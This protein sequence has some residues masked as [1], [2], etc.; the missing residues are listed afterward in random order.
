MKKRISVIVAFVVIFTMVVSLPMTSFATG[1]ESDLQTQDVVQETVTAEAEEPV[2]SEEEPVQELQ[3]EYNMTSRQ[4]GTDV[5]YDY[6]TSQNAE[7]LQNDEVSVK[8]SN[9][10]KLDF[11]IDG[12]KIVV[13]ASALTVD[14]L[15]YLTVDGKTFEADF[16][17][18]EEPAAEDSAKEEATE[19]DSDVSETDSDVAVEEEPAAE[20]EADQTQQPEEG[21]A[22]LET[23]ETVIQLEDMTLWT[24]IQLFSNEA[25][26]Y[27]YDRSLEEYSD[28]DVSGSEW[29]VPYTK[30]G[31]IAWTPAKLRYVVDQYGDAQQYGGYCMDF[32][33][34]VVDKSS[35]SR[36]TLGEADY[37]DKAV[38]GNLRSI[39]KNS[40]PVISLD[41]LISNMKA[42]GYSVS[43]LTMGQAVAGTQWA[44]WA[45]SNTASS[46]VDIP[47]KA[48][49]KTNKEKV[50]R[51]LYDLNPVTEGYQTEPIVFDITSYQKDDTVIF[52]YSNTSNAAA[53]AGLKDLDITVTDGNGKVLDYTT[54]GY[55]IIV[56]ISGME[57]DTKIHLTISGMQ[58]LAGD[59]YF[60]WPEQTGDSQRGS[61]QSLVSYFD[62]YTAVK[63]TANFS[64]DA[65][66]KG[67][68][69]LKG[70]KVLAG[71]ELTSNDSFDFV[72]KDENGKTVS[73]GT[74]NG[75]EITFEPITY[76]N[77]QVGK[78]FTYYA[79]EVNGGETVN[80]VTYDNSNLKFTVSVGF[81]N[82]SLA[83]DVVYE[84]GDGIEFTNTYGAKETSLALKVK[85]ELTGNKKM[86]AGMFDFTKVACDKDGN[87]LENADAVTA[88]NNENGEVLFGEDS[89]DKAGTYYYL[90]TENNG[91]QKID[92]ITY[93]NMK[94]VVKV[95]VEDNLEGDL[96][97]TAAYPEDVTFD[98]CYEA[99]AAK[100]AFGGKKVLEGRDLKA[101]EYEFTLSTGGTAIETVTNDAEG[102]ISFS[103]ITYTEAGEYTYT[104]SEVKGDA[105]GVT[106]DENVYTVT[107]KV[108]DDGLGQL[109]A[110]IADQKQDIVFSNTYKGVGQ[111]SVTKVFLMND[112]EA[113]ITTSFEVGLFTDADCTQKAL[114][115]D[116]SEVPNQMIEM[117]NASA[118]T[119]TFD[120]LEYGTYYVAEIGADGNAL[121]AG[122]VTGKLSQM[123]Y[124]QVVSYENTEIV[125][126]SE[127]KASDATVITNSFYDEEY[128]LSGKI[129]VTKKVTV[130]G[131]PVKADATYYVAL[132]EDEALTTMISDVKAIVLEDAEF[133]S[134]TFDKLSIDATYYV[135]ETDAAGNVINSGDFDIET[136]SIENGVIAITA[137]DREH[138]AVITNDYSENYWDEDEEQEE[139]E[140]SED[141]DKNAQTGDDLNME[142]Y[143]G[144][145]LAALA[146]MA[147]AAGRR[148]TS[149][150][151]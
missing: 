119:V 56:N 43:G 13:D 24:G 138:D 34:H 133:G 19:E 7:V 28:W 1:I 52:D 87:A 17:A 134:V 74:N 142:L 107:V 140:S 26:D 129:T 65:D 93:D 145:M 47:S 15:I 112:K 123:A 143:G 108:T 29:Y 42:A 147:V 5:I 91:G 121:V 113:A 83:M 63:G 122:D 117:N 64:F 84:D 125:L 127:N 50:A 89:Y 88:T 144:L 70:T 12:Y 53:V 73:E 86:A 101:G 31:T 100:L 6:S 106:Y 36:T 118:G 55:Q 49:A 14:Q 22:L 8:D 58:D 23:A 46:V 68:L 18:P 124:K 67:E 126:D 4:E 25:Y 80:G 75:K 136:V 59:V 71:R 141:Q 135:A 16:T 76:T 99:A 44:I 115:A 96:V 10:E 54:S 77:A 150:R 9:G 38:T 20:E 81:E 137:D 66:L 94:V 120:G 109:H 37:I 33:T 111:I 132:F 32:D 48:N 130:A 2:V 110:E 11:D 78:T 40:V 69:T 30:G 103:E 114:Y 41:Q 95:T 98:N 97:A 60:Y 149:N 51:Y 105:E 82:G 146:A 61:S 79:A 148:R 35:Y 131:T 72:I 27:T 104:I 128:Y 85:K 151:E 57:K 90:I 21:A 139:S 102:N 39:L 116:G 62:G 45:Y 92:G 3:V